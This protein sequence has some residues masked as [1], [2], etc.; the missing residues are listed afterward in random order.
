MTCPEN[1]RK[2]RLLMVVSLVATWLAHA[3]SLCVAADPLM[4]VSDFEG[5][6]VHVLEIDEAARSVSFVPGGDP[7]RG[8]PCWWY[9][10]V[11]GITPD[12]TITLRLRG[13][14]A[15]VEKRKPLSASW[16][17]PAQATFS[18]DGET[19]LHTEKGQRQDEWM[20]YTL[21]PGCARRCSSLGARPTRRALP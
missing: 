21:K 18:I 10:R 1:F 4:V 16:A 11:D 2:Q 6:S 20:I 9:F 17:M 14:T 15:T 7:V 8:W 5:A 12:E 13:S 3:P 19:W